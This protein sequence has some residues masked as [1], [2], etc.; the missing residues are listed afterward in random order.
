MVRV[1]RQEMLDEHGGVL[2]RTLSP[3]KMMERCIAQ[4]GLFSGSAN[5]VKRMPSRKRAVYLASLDNCRECLLREQCLGRGAKGDRAR[6]VS[7]VRRLLPAPSSLEPQTG[8]L[9][10]KRW[11]D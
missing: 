3:S 4:R 9:A 10:A 8:V 1:S 6:L 5:G 11:V 2:E 7:A